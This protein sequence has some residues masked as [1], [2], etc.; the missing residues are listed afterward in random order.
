M[1]VWKRLQR[2]GKSA[3]KF[4]FTASYQ[5]LEV[6]CT[7]KWQPNKLC[8]V[9]TRRSRR[10]STQLHTWEPT[11]QNPYNGMVTWTVPENV[12]TQVTLFRDG[13]HA[14]YEDKEWTFLL[15]DQARGGRRKIIA[16]APINMKDYAS[17]VPTQ[18]TMT[19]KLKP[20]SKKIVKASIQLTLSC[21][22]LREG[23]A[24]DEDMQSVA[25]LMSI[26]KTDI[27]NLDELEEE[28]ENI[29]DHSG[30][31]SF[32]SRIAEITTQLSNLDE[33]DETAVEQSENSVT[34]TEALESSNPFGDDDEE[35]DE[36]NPFK[37][38]TPPDRYLTSDVVNSSKAK[39]TKR[40]PAPPQVESSPS[41]KKTESTPRATP[42]KS[43]V[44]KVLNPPGEQS[45][46]TKK[47]APA[48]PQS[49]ET[50]LK[51][52]VSLTKKPKSPSSPE[53]PVY[54]GSPPSTTAEKWKRPI[55]PPHLQT[56]SE[57]PNESITDVSID[58]VSPDSKGDRKALETL[59]LNKQTGS[60]V[61]KSGDS[62][63]TLLEWCKEV[64]Q[65]HKGVKITNLTT[66]WRNG[67]AFCAIIAHFR[68]DLIDFRSLNPHDM[69]ANNRI[70]FD[71]AAKLGIPRV[72][73]PSD[74]VLL[75]VPDK[76]SVMT[77]LHQ[78]RAYFTG[79]TLEIQQIG[80]SARESTYTLSEKDR[81]LEMQISREMYGKDVM[82]SAQPSKENVPKPEV[83]SRKKSKSR[84]TT[85]VTPDSLSFT[86]S[87]PSNSLDKLSEISSH[88]PVKQSPEREVTLTNGDIKKSPSPDKN[89]SCDNNKL[90]SQT[91]EKP[92]VSV[93]KS[94]T[95]LMTR[96]QLNN[97]FDSE[98][99]DM[100]PASG[101]VEGEDDSEVWV[102]R[103]DSQTSSIASG[104]VSPQWS[105]KE[106]T[107]SREKSPVV[108]KHLRRYQKNTE[109]QPTNNKARHEELKAK[110][111]ILLEKAKQE[112]IV[113]TKENKQNTSETGKASQEEEDK[114]HRLKERARQLIEETRASIGKPQMSDINPS[115]SSSQRT[116]IN[117]ES[118]ASVTASIES[119]VKGD[120]KLKRLSLKKVDLSTPFSKDNTPSPQVSQPDKAVLNNKQEK[121][122][123][124]PAVNIS[125]SMEFSKEDGGD[126]SDN[127]ESLE[128]DL[129]YKKNENF[130][131]TNQYVMAEMDALD[132]EQKQIDA[133]AGLLEEKLRKAMNGNNKSLEEKLM[134]QWFLLV[135]KRNALIRRQMQLNI[136]EKEDDL[137]QR[138]ELLNREL[139]AMMAMEDWQKTEAQ[140]RREKLL[141]EELVA[142]VNKRDELVQHLD[143]QERAIEEE[144]QLDRKISEG[145]LLKQDKKECSIQ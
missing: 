48:P 102:L 61:S 55:T 132:R 46:S 113:E 68:P 33:E 119:S 39:K 41:P 3:S 143:S 37:D 116:K 121:K 50:A 97:P 17:D 93:E 110:A 80:T 36:N 12:E 20:A 52:I 85:P 112:A 134:Q 111:K 120:S 8:I 125:Y 126:S 108:E 140:K 26:G 123:V 5:E 90:M 136:L 19:I 21:V 56:K 92:S 31:H 115:V 64:T 122:K 9:W 65:G 11:I 91:K 145:K 100:S 138:Y 49:I 83:D 89:N 77:Y 99:E 131:S 1:S 118:E 133:E 137:E 101:H 42:E 13:R 76:L 38:P 62:T 35:E 51:E 74:M 78:L 57:S 18:H 84:E 70:A 104:S 53:R 4:Q 67:M 81:E 75:K 106:S 28:G 69:K 109:K 24:T 79:Q 63:Q 86:S 71:A 2:V 82:D 44:A 128:E 127:T 15:E 58:V 7:K 144:E 14:E 59:D 30:D 22:F 40:A 45:P 16:S 6:E 25:S 23:K 117:T 142:I 103:S 54:E 34:L 72:I 107:P 88:S 141:L 66:S 32:C 130:Q 10:K 114:K 73:E 129:L 139:R 95:S 47:R 43:S 27:G 87:S 29:G 60:P 105:S 98:E 135:N 94:K 124:V 96:N